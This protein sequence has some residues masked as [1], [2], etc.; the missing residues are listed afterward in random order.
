MDL[1][2][3]QDL[4][5]HNLE[6]TFFFSIYY[7]YILIVPMIFEIICNMVYLILYKELFYIIEI[8]QILRNK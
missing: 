8:I 1:V 6:T 3:F 7:K 2:F 5:S 4:N